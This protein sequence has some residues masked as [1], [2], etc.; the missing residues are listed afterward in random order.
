MK[1]LEV[2]ISLPNSLDD[3]VIIDAARTCEDLGFDS[4]WSI[5]GV[6]DEF[7]E[8][9]YDMKV[10]LA[11]LATATEKIRIGSCV[12]ATCREYPFNIARFFATLDRYSKGR[13]IA[14]LGAGV[15]SQAIPF[16]VP[17]I[18]NML[19]RFKE[20][21][22]ITKLL[23]TQEKVTYKGKYF[24]LNS[25]SL[26]SESLQKPHPPLWLG[27]NFDRAIRETAEFADGW[28]P[29]VTTPKLYREELNIFLESIEKVRRNSKEITPACFEMINISKSK[30]R[31]PGKDR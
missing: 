11:A 23:F 27:T 12:M 6:M 5:D 10:C 20:V 24:T 15:A 13:V 25:A 29:G 18:P 1:K 3:P 26:E 17:P 8:R 16:G 4:V 21:L 14:G 7:I 9:T 30:K 31:I 28:L 19:E 2:G 22:K